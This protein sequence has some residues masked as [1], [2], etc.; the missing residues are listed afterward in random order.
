[1]S[2]TGDNETRNENGNMVTLEL[3]VSCNTFWKYEMKLRV[4]RDE[5][6]DPDNNNNFNINGCCN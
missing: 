6:V 4:D 1:M 5:Y 3:R 2:T